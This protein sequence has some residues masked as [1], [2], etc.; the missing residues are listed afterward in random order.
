IPLEFPLAPK[1]RSC[2]SKSATLRPRNAASRATP[3]PFTPPP[4]TITSTSVDRPLSRPSRAELGPPCS[5]PQRY[6]IG[7]DFFAGLVN[8]APTPFVRRA[9]LA[10][11]GHVVAAAHGLEPNPAVIRVPGHAAA[12][13]RAAFPEAILARSALVVARARVARAGR[14][15]LT[16]PRIVRR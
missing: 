12:G 10:R 2:R 11:V 15:H 3:V 14:R 8:L 5:I 16:T 1:A 6:Y 7:L 9:S 13:P 4:M